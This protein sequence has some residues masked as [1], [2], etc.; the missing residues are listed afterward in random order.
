MTVRAIK[1]LTMVRG[2]L[3][4]PVPTCIAQY[5]STPWSVSGIVRTHFDTNQK[6]IRV[7]DE[8]IDLSMGSC[9]SNIFILQ[10]N[11]LATQYGWMPG[12]FLEIIFREATC[13]HWRL[14]E[15]FLSSKMVLDH[16]EVVSLF[17]EREFEDLDFLPN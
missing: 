6:L 17:P 10:D 9:E 8:E 11:R 1:K 7:I 4:M 3:A 2:H 15:G 16:K 12:E 13:A 5:Y 14:K